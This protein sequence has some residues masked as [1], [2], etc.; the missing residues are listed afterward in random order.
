MPETI[1]LDTDLVKKIIQ[2]LIR[3]DSLEITN[4]YLIKQGI[5]YVNNTALIEELERL[6]MKHYYNILKNKNSSVDLN[7]LLD[8]YTPQFINYDKYFFEL[9]KEDVSSV[10]VDEQKEYNL[11]KY[12]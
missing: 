10:F 11:N 12:F 4:D 3:S 7:E 1:G 9:K 8:Y 6:L 2:Q 5:Y